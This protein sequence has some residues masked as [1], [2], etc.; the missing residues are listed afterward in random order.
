MVNS[1][2]VRPEVTNSGIELDK[3]NPM[4]PN[5]D[6]MPDNKKTDLRIYSAVKLLIDV[7]VSQVKQSHDQIAPE[8]QDHSS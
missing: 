5:H 8:S 3:Q 6:L 4:I 7:L 1:I 2:P